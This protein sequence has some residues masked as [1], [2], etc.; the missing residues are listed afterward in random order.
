MMPYHATM[1]RDKDKDRACAMRSTLTHLLGSCLLR[2]SE[3]D[4]A[5]VCLTDCLAL[6]RARAMLGSDNYIVRG[7]II[8]SY[9]CQVRGPHEGLMRVSSHAGL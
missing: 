4:E 8:L 5:Y 3:V 6:M 7:H 9:Q 1:I 2:Q